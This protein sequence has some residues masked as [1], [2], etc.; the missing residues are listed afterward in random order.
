MTPV[1]AANSCNELCMQL[2]A[3]H[4]YQLRIAL[5]LTQLCQLLTFPKQLGLI[6]FGG[7][8]VLIWM[9]TGQA[10]CSAF[11]ELLLPDHGKKWKAVPDH[12]CVAAVLF[13][14]KQNNSK[15]GSEKDSK[16]GHRCF[17]TGP[18]EQNTSSFRTRGRCHLFL[19]WVGKNLGTR[20]SN[21]IKLRAFAR[22]SSALREG[23][24]EL[25]WGF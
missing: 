20:L 13:L 25:W 2:M 5:L 9:N 4:F 7:E 3:V 6:F 15:W 1:G 21:H 14:N 24:L 16:L 8:D 17:A 19:V 23:Q 10:G 18:R 12:F 22:I 11:L